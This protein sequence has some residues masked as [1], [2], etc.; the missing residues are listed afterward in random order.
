MENQEKS[1]EKNHTQ[2]QSH[3]SLLISVFVTLIILTLLTVTASKIN[4]GSDAVNITIAMGIASIK[5]W[6]VL[7]YFMHLKWESK[8]I[9]IFAG[10]SMP[11]V[12][13]LVI[14]EVIDVA[15]RII[16]KQF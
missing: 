12:F 14:F 13:L 5:G 8:L 15:F 16:E 6:C 7:F 10:L 3:F 1:V 2:H 9:R 4:F 11:F